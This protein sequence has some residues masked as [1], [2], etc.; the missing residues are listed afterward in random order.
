[1]TNPERQGPL[2]YSYVRFSS[3]QQ[4]MGDSL[5]RQ[6]ELTERYCEKKGLTLARAS[7]YRDLGVSAFRKKNLETG[8]LAEFIDAVKAGKV[9]PGSYLIVEQFDRL[10]RANVNVALKLLLDLIDAGIV[11]V[12][13]IDEKEWSKESVSDL[14]DLFTAIIY[15]ARANDESARKS[16]RLSAV[17]DQKK[18]RAADGTA[19]RIVTSECPRWLRANADKTGFEPVPELVDS[20]RRVFEMRISGAGA[21]AICSRA[22]RECWPAPGKSP[23]RKAGEADEDFAQRK[24]AS[25]KWHLSLVSRLLKNRAVLGEYQPRRVD[26]EDSK[27]RIPVG[28]AIRGYYPAIIDEQTFLRAQATSLRRGVRPGRRDAQGRNWLYGL[29]KCGACGNSLVR[30]NKTSSKQPGYARYYCVARVRGVTKCDSVS[31]TQLEDCVSYVAANWLPSYWR[32]DSSFETLKA[33]ADVLETQITESK[34]SIDRL[35][36]LASGV[37][38]PAARKT[39]IERLDREGEALTASE[40]EL[41]RVRAELADHAQLSGTDEWAATL[42]KTFREIGELGAGEDGVDGAL[43][44]REE[45]AR[46]VQKIV[47]HQSTRHIEF[48][49]KGVAEPVWLPLDFA[50]VTAPTDPSDEQLQAAMRDLDALKLAS[51]V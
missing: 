34:A 41:A 44:L 26:R 21:A 45:L 47:V 29:V 25:G 18:K 23:V 3:A 5:R 11:V 7:A 15:M 40:K 20:I 51:A 48:F 27:N 1:M 32:N 8:K 19:T 12:T 38:A 39:L 17:W 9:P 50:G 10:S 2:A 28:E 42:E 24:E 13:L 36:D 33:R 6:V 49:L 43:R 22:N 31:S 14:G 4:S 16:D 35:A 37:T 46:I 30:K